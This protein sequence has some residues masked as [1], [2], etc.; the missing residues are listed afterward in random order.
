M[1]LAVWRFFPGRGSEKLPIKN[2]TSS[3]LSARSHDETCSLAG[4]LPMGRYLSI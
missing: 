4:S 3:K 2:G 1:G